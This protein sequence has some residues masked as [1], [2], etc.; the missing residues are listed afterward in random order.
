[1]K[2]SFTILILIFCIPIYS[3]KTN[4]GTSLDQNFNQE[5]E[6][7]KALSWI[8]DPA[9][10]KIDI[11]NLEGAPEQNIVFLNYMKNSW[12]PMANKI[13]A[14]NMKFYVYLV[15]LD[16]AL[17][18]DEAEKKQWTEAVNFHTKEKNKIIQSAQFHQATDKLHDL[19][20]G[21]RGEVVDLVNRY[22]NQLINF[23]PQKKDQAVTNELTHLRST[24][25]DLA[26][27]SKITSAMLAK[28]AKETIEIKNDFYIGKIDILEASRKIDSLASWGL[29][30]KGQDVAISASEALN[31]AAILYSKLARS[32]GYQSH[33]EFIFAQKEDAYS[34]GMKTPQERIKTLQSTLAQI[35][36]IMT[37]VYRSLWQKQIPH[38]K[39]EDLT[40]TQ[41]SLLLPETDSLVTEYFIKENATKFWHQ[42]F[43]ENGFDMKQLD[44]LVLD[45]YPRAGKQSQAYMAPQSIRKPKVFRVDAKT[46]AVKVPPKQAKN[47][48]PARITILSNLL[49]DTPVSYVTLGH[50]EGHYLDYSSR[51][52]TDGPFM[53]IDKEGDP[54]EAT[55]RSETPSIAMEKVL[56]DRPTLLD[57]LIDKEGN[58]IP[59]GILDQYLSN[60]KIDNL[61]RFIH[62]ATGALFD[63]TLWSYNFTEDSETFVERAR[64]LAR[65]MKHEYGIG[66]TPFLSIDTSYQYFGTGHFYGAS[67]KY[68]YFYA[69][70]TAEMVDQW[71]LDTLENISGERTY[72]KQYQMADTLIN[73]LYAD[74]HNATYPKSIEHFTK[75]KFNSDELVA[76]FEKSAD[77]ICNI[78]MAPF[79]K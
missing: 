15:S 71:L 6:R 18:N 64:G 76:N 58:P 10:P 47:W 37:Q 75:R 35:K 8:Q 56:N 39:F 62:T 11:V 45:L 73:N 17:Y 43:E 40:T 72:L 57:K 5:K 30:A 2:H 49:T 13:Q 54:I 34:K 61:L 68:D 38:L 21:L 32:K 23:E 69:S 66:K 41:L 52:F 74:T 19:S 28:T 1:M 59:E 4:K 36:P 26:N 24:V 14:H 33:A 78:K 79:I 22:W 60:K 67:V 16:R 9:V 65:H 48:Y 44:E 20:Q 12:A 50:E 27:N 25:S 42:I 46:L 3:V 63:Y 31:Q 7:A 51:N 29:L 70:Q 77:Q 53:L 55:S